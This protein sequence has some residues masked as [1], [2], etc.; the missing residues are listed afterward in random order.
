MFNVAFKTDWLS[1]QM[2]NF[3]RSHSMNSIAFSIA[4]ASARN[5][6]QNDWSVPMLRITP[7]SLTTA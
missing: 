2:T 4:V 7:F 5:T 1:V 6:E 3:P